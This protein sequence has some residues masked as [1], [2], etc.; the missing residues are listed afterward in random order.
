M[1]EKRMKKVIADL[2]FDINLLFND[3]E[4]EKIDSKTMIEKITNLCFYFL[5]VVID[6]ATK[7]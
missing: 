1:E 6:N 7:K 5:R 4:K 3:W 2:H